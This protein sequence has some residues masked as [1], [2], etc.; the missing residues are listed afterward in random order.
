MRSEIVLLIFGVRE[1]K[2]EG[3]RA[4]KRRG[5][6]FV[7]IRLPPGRVPLAGQADVGTCGQA[8]WVGG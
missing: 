5:A 7:A 8:G 4:G 1:D 2:A 6:L 3:G